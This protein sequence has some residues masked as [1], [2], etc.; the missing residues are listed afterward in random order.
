MGKYVISTSILTCMT[1]T[2]SLS[3][4]LYIYMSISI[5]TN[6]AKTSPFQNV[7]FSKAQMD[8]ITECGGSGAGALDMS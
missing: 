8:V 1:H 7:D 3:L 4:S 2:H 6:T 5:N